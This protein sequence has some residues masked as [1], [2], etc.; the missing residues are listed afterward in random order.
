MMLDNPAYGNTGLSETPE[1]YIMV[2]ACGLEGGG[3]RFMGLWVYVVH[4]PLY[5]YLVLSEPLHFALRTLRVRVQR[6]P[7]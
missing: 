4:C 7:V 6:I 2:V 1:N 5:D 3:C